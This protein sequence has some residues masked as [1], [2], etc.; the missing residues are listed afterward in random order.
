MDI[1]RKIWTV[2][3]KYSRKGLY[4]STNK[5]LKLR[6]KRKQSQRYKDLKNEIYNL[7]WNEEYGIKLLSQ[8]L[9]L[10]Y[11]VTRNILEFLDIPMRKGQNVVTNRLR[12]F[13]KEKALLEGKNKTGWNSPDVNRKYKKH[14]RGVQGFYYNK[15]M[16][17]YVWLRST[18]EYI[19]AKWLDKIGEKWDV[20]V[21]YYNTNGSLYRPDFFIY[22]ENDNIQKIVEI[23]G[24]WDSNTDKVS[25]LNEKLMNI[26][27]IVI[28]NV[29]KYIEQNSHYHVEL[30]R[31]K[32]E[33]KKEEEIYG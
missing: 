5:R 26:D 21:K 6:E 30:A 29:E 1:Q 20:E 25:L 10:T 33:K 7:Y 18:W 4:A 31:W 13:R 12:K 22:D 11:S 27:V 17:K 23:N 9:N 32:K 24:Y 14:N 2:Y 8:K 19:Y 28:Y 16:E 15:S 3:G